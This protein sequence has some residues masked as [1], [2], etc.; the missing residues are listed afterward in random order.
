MTKKA[1]KICFEFAEE[2][3]YSLYDSFS[4]LQTLGYEEFGICG[5]FEEGD[6]YEFLT[7][8]VNGD[9]PF[10]EPNEYF[11]LENVMTDLK[12]SLNPKRRITWGMAWVK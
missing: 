2:M 5:F 11:P 8:D 1:N 6:K 4:Y 7:Y 12:E 9:T 3:D 10:K